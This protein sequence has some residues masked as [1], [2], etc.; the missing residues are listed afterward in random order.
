[1]ISAADAG[2]EQ[3]RLAYEVYVYRIQTSVAAMTAAMEGLDGLVF[4]GGAGEA[5]SRLRADTCSRL[6]FLG[7]RLDDSRNEGIR[8]DGSVSPDGAAPVVLVVEAREDLE[9][10]RHARALLG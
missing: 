8:G 1:V 6:G 4:S 2:N 7:L 9:I 3:A 5:S 10:A